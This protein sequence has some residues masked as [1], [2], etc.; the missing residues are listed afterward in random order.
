MPISAL[1]L[2]DRF[3]VRPGETVATDGVVESGDP[4]STPQ[5]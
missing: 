5:G 2:D 4:R 1:A 3:V